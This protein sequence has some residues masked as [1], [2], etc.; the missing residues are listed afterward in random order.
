MRWPVVVGRQYRIHTQ[1][2]ASYVERW[3]VPACVGEVGADASRES[4]ATYRLRLQGGRVLDMARVNGSGE[5]TEETQTP[6]EKESW[7]EGVAEWL[8][9]YRSGGTNIQS[10]LASTRGSRR[11]DADDR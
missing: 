11:T 2:C 6:Y 8:F 9:A 4:N 3:G 10:A 7:T 5:L 1:Y